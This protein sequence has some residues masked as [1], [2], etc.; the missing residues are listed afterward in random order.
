MTKFPPEMA[1]SA[2]HQ[3]GR[4]MERL[5]SRA[6][7]TGRADYTHNVVLPRMLHAKILRSTVAHGRI[8]SINV[9]AAQA[10]EGVH[11]VVTGADVLRV[12]PEPYFG[13]A[14]HDQPIL[15][16]DKVRYVGEPVAVVLA[17][18]PHV[19]EA[20]THLIDV[21]YAPLPA[22]FNEVEAASSIAV[23]HDELK[24]AGTF[25]DL[26]HLA[27]RRMTNVALDFRV[28]RGNVDK[29]FA[30]AE[31]VFDDTFTT[32]QVMHVPL[33]PMISIAEP[34]DGTMILHTASQSPS[35]VRIEIARLLGWRENQV[36]VK[37]RHLGGGFGAKLYIKLEALAVALALLARRPV[38]VALTMEEQFFTITKHATTFRIQ[39]AV[40]KNG[41][42]TG[43][44]CEVWWN[45]GAYADI[46][47]RVTQKSGFTAS[48]P[49][50]IENVQIDSYQVYTNLP[51]AGAFRGFGITQV[52]WGYE[53]QADI[54]ARALKIDP[55]EFRR[56]NLLKNGRPHAT[57][58]VMQDAALELVLDR[59][60]ARMQWTAP[61]DK[62]NG[63]LR[64]GRG[65]GIGFKAVVA[66]TTSVAT[67]SLQ[68][69]G[70]C[71][72]QVGTVDM[73]QGSDTA[74][75]LIAGEVLGMPAERIHVTRPDTDTTPY[76][77]ATLGSR[78]TFHMGH[79]VR[80]AAEHVVAQLKQLAEELGEPWR[81]VSS[82][83]GLLR[84]KYG[85]QAGNIIGIGSFIPSYQSPDHD[86]GQS[87]DITPNWMIGAS[88]VEVEVDTETGHFRLVR[89][90]N[91]VDCGTPINPKIV[92]TQ[93]SGA[94]IMQLGMAL[95]EQMEFDDEGQLRNAS[96]SEYKIPG[97]HDIPETIGCEIAD[98]TQSNGP[99][100]A[101]G[102]GE[103]ATFGVASAIAAAI[104]DA[105]GV[106]L[107]SL[108]LKPEAVFRAMA[109]VCGEAIGQE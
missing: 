100:G 22:V 59:V 28:R 52:V 81:G 25:P 84:K 10:T 17:A 78:S 51:P 83:G 76:D 87:P 34:G 41:I 49:Y 50:D 79:A 85:M 45:G 26:K 102:V 92:E 86:S 96:F 74:M 104:E 23:V 54:I 6:K 38:K 109:K 67:I 90:E 4:R 1:N 21:E 8:V 61:F 58:T 15:A 30:E 24:P 82:A 40:D 98:A 32:Q 73:G 35:F 37:T 19:A 70:S 57:G 99:Y 47:P 7:V 60:A 72:L 101:K 62:G 18:D 53:C 97:I 16:I 29:A 36:Q 93:I 12:I 68:G 89:F 13:P 39:S 46:G 44:R 95:Q 31:H 2:I 77:M 105:V 80:L 65:I 20:A 33:E 14:F 106:R 48:G 64:R 63:S 91:V 107:K 103:S 9:Q 5:E 75:A 43:R 42:I 88:G 11:S 3:V 69:D 56:R 71:I 55:I 66:P 27:G 94:A 108:P